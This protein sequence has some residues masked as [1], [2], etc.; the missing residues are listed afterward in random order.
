MLTCYNNY[1]NDPGVGIVQQQREQNCIAASVYGS[2]TTL[3]TAPATTTGASVTIT[4]TDLA[5][6]TSIHTG[7]TSKTGS[8]A[9]S[10]PSSSFLGNSA[11]GL[12]VTG[13]LVAMALAGLRF[14]L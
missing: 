8:S 1:P 14:V 9:T 2:T 7:F 12:E 3:G 4:F 6:D 5:S 13:S 11:A 10:N